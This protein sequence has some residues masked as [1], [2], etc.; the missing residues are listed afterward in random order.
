[1]KQINPFLSKG[2]KLLDKVKHTALVTAFSL[3]QPSFLADHFKSISVPLYFQAMQL[4]HGEILPGECFSCIHDMIFFF[5][6]EMNIA[7]VF[8]KKENLN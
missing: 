1:M 3:M 4:P 6:T 8:C 7:V 5:V 2:S